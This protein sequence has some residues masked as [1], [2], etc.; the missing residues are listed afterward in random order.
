MDLEDKDVLYESKDPKK[1]ILFYTPFVEQKKDIDR[2]STPYSIKAPFKLVHADIADIQ[3]FSKS[4]VEPKYCLLA[5][6]ICTSKRY[7]YPMKSW[8]LLAQKNGTFLST[9][10]AEE[11]A[12][13]KKLVYACLEEKFML[14]NRKLESSRSF[15]SK[16]K[17]HTRQPPALDSLRKK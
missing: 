2:P 6:D 16:A 4:A 17:K 3:F 12:G 13:C 5:V 7:T 9:Y 14:Q 1:S 8:H 15:C 10:S 11:V